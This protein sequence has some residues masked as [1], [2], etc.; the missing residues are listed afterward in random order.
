M[1]ITLT[2]E[3]DAAIESARGWYTGC[4]TTLGPDGNYAGGVFRLFGAAGVGKTEL[5]KYLPD[6]L[7][8][9]NVVF[10]AYTG[11]A[12]S[13]LNRKGVPATTIH[14][15][16]Y[17]PVFSAETRKRWLEAVNRIADLGSQS[18]MTSSD[19]EELEALEAEADELQ[20]EMRRPGFELNPMSEWASADL[21]V[22]DEVSM[23][24]A[25]MAADIES[26]GVPVLVLGDPAQLPPVGGMGYY[27]DAE[28]DVLLTEIHRQALESPVLELATRI[29]LSDDATLGVRPDEIGVAS[30]TRALEAEQVLCWRNETRWKLT[31]LMRAKLGRP[32]G[33]VVAGDRIMCLVNNKRDLGV[34]N[35]QQFDVLDVAGDTLLLRECGTAGPDRWITVFPEG[36]AGLDGEKSLKDRRAFRGTTMAATYALV[37][38]VHKAQ[39]SEWSSV[40]VVDETPA[41]MAMTARREGERAAVEMARRWMYTATTRAQESVTLARTRS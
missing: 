16:I 37:C 38:T 8:L 7:G 30:V 21:I 22:L 40:Y 19:R 4:M 2:A 12:A 13:V 33:V 31:G 34:L 10:G 24:D 20:A 28:P 32:A 3:Q 17:Q 29:R 18:S 39:G 23:V 6:A 26:F 41:M 9:D 27:T 11:K 5:A 14:S 25:K 36:F 35:G 15:A 1:T